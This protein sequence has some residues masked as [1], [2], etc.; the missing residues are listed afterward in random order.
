MLHT[1]HTASTNAL[2]VGETM[3]RTACRWPLL[4]A[5]LAAAAAAYWAH[6]TAEREDG[7][8]CREEEALCGQIEPPQRQSQRCICSRERTIVP[9]KARVKNLICWKIYSNSACVMSLH[10]EPN[11]QF[12]THLSM[13]FLLELHNFQIFFEF[14]YFNYSHLFKCE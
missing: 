3:E 1:A 2:T 14:T 10:V 8:T 5:D 7:D 6:R 9:G 4:A 12:K 11:Y 13:D